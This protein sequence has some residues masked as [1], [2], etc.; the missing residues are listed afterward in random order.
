M[1][2]TRRQS[3]AAVVVPVFNR[4]KLLQPTVESLKMQT[5]ADAEFILVD[6]RSDETVWSY[7]QS[8]PG[9]DSRFTV[10]RKP[11]DIERGCQASRN[12]GLDACAA[13]TVLFLDSDDLLAP[14]CLADRQA[15]F[16][17]NPDAAIVVGRQ[18]MFSESGDAQHWVN[19][20][21]GDVDDLS[22]FLQIG[23]PIDV[24]WVNGG[25]TIRTS[26]LRSARV[27]W[28]PE[29]HWDDVAF[30]VECLTAGMQAVRVAFPGP[31]DAYYR[32]HTGEKYGNVLFTADGIR[33]T[34]T[35]L[36][37]IHRTLKTANA[38]DERR[39]QILAFSFFQTCLLRA[40]DQGEYSL[41]HQLTADAALAGLLSGSDAWR[42]QTF[43]AGRVAFRHSRRL[44]WYW[45]RLMRPTLL[46]DYYSDRISTYGTM[47]LPA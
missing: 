26:E 24:P 21:R 20:P 40:V 4:L 45:N 33:S 47:P 44:T 23:H 13:D 2:D 42:M 36:R 9:A 35:M 25:V 34:A 3:A 12:I 1:S 18:V 6:D 32:Q 7:L 22:R 11:A 29:F 15:A 8:L 17:A 31:P 28:R 14:T 39:Q 38:L 41:A 43:R 19:V 10:I 5:L 46:A 30:H 27:R 37:W 16:D